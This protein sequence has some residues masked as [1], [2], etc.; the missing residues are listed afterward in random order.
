MKS[1]LV[2]AK[3]ESIVVLHSNEQSHL[4]DENHEGFRFQNELLLPFI[5]LKL[6]PGLVQIFFDCV[7]KLV[8]KLPHRRTAKPNRLGIDRGHLQLTPVVADKEIAPLNFSHRNDLPREEFACVLGHSG[9]DVI[10]FL[11][12]W[13]HLR[14]TLGQHPHFIH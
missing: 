10:V 12:G 9:F 7:G 1:L 11:E 8:A 2:L 14:R 6:H 13:F 3:D 4:S 5:H